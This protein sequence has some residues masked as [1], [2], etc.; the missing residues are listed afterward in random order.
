MS[1]RYLDL[2]KHYDTV[3]VYYYDDQDD[4]SGDV[5]MACV[6]TEDMRSSSTDDRARGNSWL[7]KT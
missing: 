6:G 1:P 4:Y 7:I 3:Y 5:C 2:R